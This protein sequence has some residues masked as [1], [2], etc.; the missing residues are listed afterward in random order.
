MK[1]ERKYKLNEKHTSNNENLLD[2]MLVWSYQLSDRKWQIEIEEYFLERYWSYFK[3]KIYNF[4]KED[5]D[6][7]NHVYYF[8]VKGLSKYKIDSKM[9]FKSFVLNLMDFYIKSLITKWRK[10][11]EKRE[12]EDFVIEEVYLWEDWEWESII[13][14]LESENEIDFVYELWNE[15][16][17]GDILD[18]VKTLWMKGEVFLDRIFGEELDWNWMTL[19]ELENKYWI[20][21]ERCRQIEEEVRKNIKLKYNFMF[22]NWKIL[23]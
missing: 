21:Y 13:E 3:R 12:S 6:L 4:F 8:I 11:E 20:C 1:M 10:K 22:D 17:I 9:S 2:T 23:L 19:K 7:E 18:Y 14:N 16:I 15:E 5:W